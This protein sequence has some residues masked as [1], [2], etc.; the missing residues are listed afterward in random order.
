MGVTIGYGSVGDVSR[1]EQS[2]GL[3]LN[4]PWEIIIGGELL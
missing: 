4:M 2:D 3:Y 1:Y